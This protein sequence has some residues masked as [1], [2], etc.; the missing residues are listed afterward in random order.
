L[1]DN[2]LCSSLTC[3]NHLKCSSLIINRT[4]D[5][6]FPYPSFHN[7][8]PRPIWVHSSSSWS[9]RVKSNKLLSRFATQR[10]TITTQQTTWATTAQIRYEVVMLVG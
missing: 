2:F 7:D 4:G 3:H 5:G 6:G 1:N 10:R 9:R 8:H